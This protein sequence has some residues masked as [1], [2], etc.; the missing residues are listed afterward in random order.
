[1]P[2]M[3]QAATNPEL[4]AGF[5][6]H[7]LQTQ[8]QIERLNQAFKLLGQEPESKTC[9]AMK[10]LIA[11]GDELL[12]EDADPQVK[13][14]LLIAAAQKVEHYEI[15]S[16]GTVCTWADLLGNNEVK[17]LLGQTLNE[18]EQTDQKLTKLAESKVNTAAA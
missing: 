11:E 7:L 3:A 2:K 6:E 10:G 4:R 12:K 14:A 17:E 1:L 18:E 16:Y 15:A 8:N 5:E 13:D 9:K